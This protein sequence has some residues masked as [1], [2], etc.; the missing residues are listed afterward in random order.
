MNIYNAIS[1][2]NKF[3]PDVGKFVSLWKIE[4]AIDNNKSF[5]VPSHVL[6]PLFANLL[7]ESPDVDQKLLGLPIGNFYYL[8]AL[9]I[10]SMNPKTVV[11]SETVMDFIYKSKLLDYVSPEL[12]FSF[13]SQAILINQ[14]FGNYDGILFCKDQIDDGF[15]KEY[16]LNI[17]LFSNDGRFGKYL[18][19]T[20]PIGEKFNP[21]QDFKDKEEWSNIAFVFYVLFYVLNEFLHKQDTLTQDGTD[22]MGFNLEHKIEQTRF[23]NGTWRNAHWHTYQ[24]KIGTGKYKKLIK[25]VQPV[26]IAD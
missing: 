26:W 8:H 2:L 20:L 19:F 6:Y 9:S 7:A 21:F 3:V 5:I 13:P 24:E 23:M 22:F 12:L 10:W 11:V 14:K 25:W 1:E 18:S 17:S 4:Q 15:T 16:S